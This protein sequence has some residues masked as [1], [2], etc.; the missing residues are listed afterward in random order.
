MALI[1]V[2]YFGYDTIRFVEKIPNQ[3]KD[4]LKIP[5]IRLQRPKKIIIHDNFKKKLFFIS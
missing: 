5:D 1:L 3:N 4:D 2:G